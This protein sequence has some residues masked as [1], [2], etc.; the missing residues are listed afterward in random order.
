MNAFPVREAVLGSSSVFRTTDPWIESPREINQ[1]PVGAW[2]TV[3]L[4]MADYPCCRTTM[5]QRGHSRY[6]R[7]FLEPIGN[8]GGGIDR[9]P[10]FG[11]GGGRVLFMED[12]Y[13][14]RSAFVTVGTGATAPDPDRCLGDRSRGAGFGIGHVLNH[15][16]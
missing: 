6:R 9:Y 4:G 1:W 7:A 15:G 3:F 11:M 5:D 12:V 2:R 16:A 8:L 14:S 10:V 13:A